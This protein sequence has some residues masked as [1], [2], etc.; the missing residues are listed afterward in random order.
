MFLWALATLFW[1]VTE[2]GSTLHYLALVVAATS[3]I[4]SFFNMNPLIKLDG[5]YLLSDALELPNLRQKA[6]AY[7]RRRVASLFTWKRPEPDVANPRERR[8][9]LIYGLLAVTYCYWLLATVLGHL[10]SY[11]VARQQGWGFTCFAVLCL[12][13]FLNHILRTA[14]ELS[15][16]PSLRRDRWG[17]S[18]W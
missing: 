13:I 1:R 2:T 5:Y 8:I 7:L 4:K 12:G 10:G 18:V 11:L 16:Q 14:A 6:T 17:R 3:A 15:A 9:Y